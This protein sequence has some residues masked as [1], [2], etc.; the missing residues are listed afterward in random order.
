MLEIRTYVTPDKAGLDNLVTRMRSR[1]EDLR[2]PWHEERDVSRRPPRRRSRTTPSSI[3]CRTTTAKRRRRTGA[4]SARMPNGRTLRKTAGAD[5]PDQDH[6]AVRHADRFL[7]GEVTRPGCT[8][9]NL[10]ALAARAADTAPAPGAVPD[11]PV[12]RGRRGTVHRGHLADGQHPRLPQRDVSARSR[13]S[14][15]CVQDARRPAARRSRISSRPSGARFHDAT[16]RGRRA[17]PDAESRRRRHA[18]ARRANGRGG[19]FTRRPAPI[20]GRRCRS[21][22]G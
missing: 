6:V 14:R 1:S 21:A 20:S 19:S 9:A 4:R 3:S 22:T 18:R 16:R 5:R 13:R 11:S 10:A 15:A 12:G 8:R 7:A 17:R 2:S